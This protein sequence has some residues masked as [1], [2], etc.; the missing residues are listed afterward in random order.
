MMKKSFCTNAQLLWDFRHFRQNLDNAL[1]DLR[2]FAKKDRTPFVNYVF[3]YA[4]N[5]VEFCVTLD[6]IRPLWK[7]RETLLIGGK[8]E[9]LYN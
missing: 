2:I 7:D 1:E 8:S 4:E 3:G 5:E 9:R 6:S